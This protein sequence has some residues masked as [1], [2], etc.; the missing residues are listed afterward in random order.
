MWGLG[1]SAIQRFSD[2][3]IQRFS[4]MTGLQ[5]KK[6]PCAVAEDSF[7]I[8]FFSEVIPGRQ[9]YLLAIS[10]APWNDHNARG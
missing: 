6:L 1:D 4:K 10:Q 8:R 2:S 7:W 5:N 3:K 9:S